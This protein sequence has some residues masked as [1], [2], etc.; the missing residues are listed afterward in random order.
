MYIPTSFAEHTLSRLHDLMERYSFTVLVTSL[1]GDLQ[2]THLPLLLD[3]VTGT[4]G[5]LIGHMAKANPHSRFLD[6]GRST[7]IYS[8]PHTYISPTWY[9]ADNVVPT[10]N[11]VAVHVT[12]A[13]EVIDDRQELLTSVRRM[14]DHY[15]SAMPEPWSLTNSPSID[16]LLDQIVGFRL[17]IERI[18]GKWKLNQNHPIERRLKVIAQLRNRADSDSQAIADLMEAGLRKSDGS[19]EYDSRGNSRD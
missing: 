17:H 9:A 18:E 14:T 7:V 4:Q 2:I 11:Y 3:R 1:E 16:K 13:T 6:G 15:E 10:W 5:M 8:G 19:N 12:G